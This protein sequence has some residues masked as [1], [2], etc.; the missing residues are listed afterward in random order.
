MKLSVI[1]N[2]TIL[3]LKSLAAFVTYI[4]DFITPIE[5]NFDHLLVCFLD[6][7]FDKKDKIYIP[8]H[9]S[10]YEFQFLFKDKTYS[11]TSSSC[12]SWE[13]PL[14]GHIPVCQPHSHGFSIITSWS[15]PSTGQLI[16]PG[17]LPRHNR[18][19]LN[20]F[21]QYTTTFHSSSVHPAYESASDDNS[22]QKMVYTT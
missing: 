4:S 13:S 22:G 5:L 14:P 9:V 1:P 17:P 7:V 19:Q 15:S 6:I 20:I 2:L 10:F 8:R 18:C 12:L 11:Y 3:F 16:L 21:F